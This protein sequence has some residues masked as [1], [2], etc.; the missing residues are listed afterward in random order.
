MTDI[1]SVGE[2]LVDLTQIGNNHAIPQYAA[3]P[4]GAPANVAVAAAKLGAK[5]AFCGKIG[6]DSFGSLLRRT[7]RENGVDDTFLYDCSAPSTLAVVSID[8]QGER[9]FSF[10][11]ENGADTLLNDGESRAALT[12]EPRFLHFG[13]VSLTHEPSRTATLS[14]AQTAKDHGCLI[15]YDPNYRP[16]LWGDAQR[17]IEQMKQPLVLTDVLKVSDEELPLLTGTPDLTEGSRLLADLGI[18]LVLVTLGAEGVFYRMREQTGR[19]SGVPVKVADTNGAGDT[20]LGAVLSRLCRRNSPLTGLC[21]EELEDIL[22][23]ANRTAAL[24][25]SRSGAIP[26]MPAL[27]EL[28]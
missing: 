1:L 3:N 5:T 25:C 13:S 26:A 24:T 20:F 19:L 23:L 18:S 17:A 2:L 4:G 12:C 8:N 7:L 16:A 6:R 11:R 15:S 21:V 28:E 22:R 10:Y 27:S 9:S 14:A